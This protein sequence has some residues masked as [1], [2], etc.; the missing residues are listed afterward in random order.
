MSNQAQFEPWQSTIMP[1]LPH[2]SKPQAYGLALWSWGMVLTRSCALTAIS[3]LLA[4]VW[5][6]KDTTMRQRVCEWYDDAPA[7]RGQKRRTLEVESC[8][9]PLLR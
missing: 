7:T 1:H 9:A 8:F 5:R 4:T 2:V 6:R 3:S